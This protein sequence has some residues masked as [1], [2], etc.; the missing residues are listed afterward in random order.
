MSGLVCVTGAKGSPG[1]TTLAAALASSVPT[2]TGRVLLIDADPDGGDLAA[3][4]GAGTNPGMV[5]LAAAT[6]HRFA[7]DD[8]ERHAQPIGET[9]SL[10]ATPPSPDQAASTLTNLGRGFA[11]SLTHTPA[12]ADLGRWRSDSPAAELVRAAAATV[13]VVRPTVAGV[14]HARW[15]FAD[16]TSRSRRVVVATRGERPYGPEEVAE[17]LGAESAV[18]VPVDRAAASAVAG[19]RWAR[20]APLGRSVRALAHSLGLVMQAESVGSTA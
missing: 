3:V 7:S 11:E 13:L 5:T 8:V 2:D 19:G 9:I 1:A 6:R 14:A 4:F 10:L 12:V 16:L 15:A 20:R 17:A 18:L